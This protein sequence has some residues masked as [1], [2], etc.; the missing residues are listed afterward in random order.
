MICLLLGIYTPPQNQI[1]FVLQAM[2]TITEPN[3]EAALIW[4]APAAIYN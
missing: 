3:M 2:Y 4:H 1:S